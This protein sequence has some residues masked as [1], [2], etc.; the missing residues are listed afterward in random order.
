MQLVV[1]SPGT[2]ITQKEG[3]FRLKNKDKVFDTKSVDVRGD[4]PKIPSTQC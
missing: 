2:F 3:C 1:N 4:R